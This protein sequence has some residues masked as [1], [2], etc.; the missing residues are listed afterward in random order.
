MPNVKLERIIVSEDR[1]RKEFDADA[2]E[3]LVRGILSKGLFHPLVL[4]HIEGKLYL[5]AGERRLRAIQEINAREQLFDFNGTPV[6]P[7]EAPYVLLGDLTPIDIREAE[8]EENILRQDLSWKERTAA[9][10][11][12]HELRKQQNPEQTQRATAEEIAK[13]SDRALRTEEREVSHAIVVAPHL[14]DP[15]VAKA[16]DL[17][18]AMNKVAR[19]LEGKFSA[20][21][22]AREGKKQVQGAHSPFT[23]IKGDLRTEMPKLKAGRFSMLIADPPYGMGADS[24]GDAA[25]L[26]HKYEDTADEAIDLCSVIFNEGFRVCAEEATLICFC[27]IDLFC[28]L[29]EMCRDAG[30]NPFRTPIIWSKYGG[31]GHMPWQDG[32]F[33]RKY[34]MML[35][36]KK[37]SRAIRKAHEDVIIVPPVKELQWAAQKPSGLYSILMSLWLHPGEEVLDPCCGVGTV[38][39]GVS[40][41]RYKATGIELN[42]EAHGLAAAA[43]HHVMAER[44]RVGWDQ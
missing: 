38:F 33:R 27:D 14:D 35:F 9:I 36:A 25:K 29:R 37:G 21:L 5:V 22:A 17:R 15:D 24:F 4:N 26:E 6:P 2:H 23:L 3:D 16:R 39:A 18:D 19:K 43:I 41:G 1:M 12:L 42:D 7:G 11:E 30:W 20:E 40:L 13:K 34:E 44:K 10:A 32:G 31:G 8:L 28:D